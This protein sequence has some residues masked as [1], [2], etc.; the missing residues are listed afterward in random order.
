[1]G[2]L[3][4]RYNYTW[5]NER[6]VETALAFEVL[7][8]HAGQD[9]LEIGNVM[10]QYVSVDHLVVDKYEHAPGVVNA[11]VVDLHLDAKFD[12]ILAVSTLEHVG[13]DEETLD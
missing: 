4:H 1:M 10:S 6:A 8:D 2:Y 3:N 13:L 7:R 9:V 12:L 5:L 11:D